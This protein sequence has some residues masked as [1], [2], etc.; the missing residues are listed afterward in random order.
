MAI[1]TVNPAN[2][3]AQ[4]IKKAQNTHN[5]THRPYETQEE[6]RPHQNVNATVLL[7]R[8]NKIISGSRESKVSGRERGWRGKRRTVRIQEEVGEKYRGSGI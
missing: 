2:P 5:T 8:R 7:K 3:Q 4:E 6:G 1:F